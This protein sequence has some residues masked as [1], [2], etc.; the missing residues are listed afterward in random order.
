MSIHEKIMALRPPV[1][2]NRT[3]TI[4]EAQ[5]ENVTSFIWNSALKEAAA[6]A[7]QCERDFIEQ[8]CLMA[9]RIENL[10]SHYA[11]SVQAHAKLLSER[12]QMLAE[13]KEVLALENTEENEWDAVEVVIPNMCTV[14]RNIIK[15]YEISK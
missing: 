6:L 11:Y 4:K 15:K 5:N 2:Q 9:D 14:V 13:L 7:V 8:E 10:E 12:A 3:G 1:A